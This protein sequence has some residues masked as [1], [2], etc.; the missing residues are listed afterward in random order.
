MRHDIQRITSN[1]IVEENKEN[2]N[3]TLVYLPKDV[4]AGKT[5]YTDSELRLLNPDPA[6][7]LNSGMGSRE[8]RRARALKYKHWMLDGKGQCV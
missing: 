1:M 8:E 5:W 4:V 6:V 7:V 2:R 3:F